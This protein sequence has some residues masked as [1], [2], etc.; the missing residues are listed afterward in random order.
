MPAPLL[1]LCLPCWY[2]SLQSQST[3]YERLASSVAAPYAH[4]Q[5]AAL[6][7][8]L[9]SL[10]LSHPLCLS[11]V[12]VKLLRL[13]YAEFEARYPYFNPR[14]PPHMAREATDHAGAVPDASSGRNS[15][16]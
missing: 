9:T 12:V 4:L 1:L 10:E 15:S 11:L 16:H 7:P 13:L 5:L 2:L 8:R 14:L 3:T 6:R